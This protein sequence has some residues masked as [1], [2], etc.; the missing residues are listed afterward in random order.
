M[1]RIISV[2]FLAA[3]LLGCSKPACQEHPPFFLKGT[4]HDCEAVRVAR[5]RSET[6]RATD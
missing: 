2:A 4:I 1:E 6:D 3:V 5:Q